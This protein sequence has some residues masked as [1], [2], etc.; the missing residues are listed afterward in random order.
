MQRPKVGKRYTLVLLDQGTLV[1]LVHFTAHDDGSAVLERPFREGRLAMDD[2]PSEACWS[3]LVRDGYIEVGEAKKDGRLLASWKA[4]LSPAEVVAEAEQ[5]EPPH[6]WKRSVY[7]FEARRT[8]TGWQ[9][10][11]GSQVR[12]PGKRAKGL[13]R[14][15]GWAVFY[16]YPYADDGEGMRDV[17]PDLVIVHVFDDG[18][19]ERS[20]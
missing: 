5:H 12:P 1:D 9:Y 13:A 14:E 15:T 6:G 4:P 17:F 18:R 8:N 19:I 20:G 3:A 10:V 11:Y 2:T 7:R 16:R